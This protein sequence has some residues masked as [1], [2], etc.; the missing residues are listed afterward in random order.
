MNA[1]AYSFEKPKTITKDVNA[2]T[3]IR[4]SRSGTITLTLS[5]PL[6]YY[7]LQNHIQYLVSGIYVISN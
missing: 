1:N 7:S 3:E 2:K 6:K 5:E 4:N